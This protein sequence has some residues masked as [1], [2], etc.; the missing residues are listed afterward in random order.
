[1]QRFATDI[2]YEGTTEGVSISQ[3]SEMLL[4][5]DWPL[6]VRHES[7][8]KGRTTG[9]HQHLDFYALYVI[10]SGKGVHVID[11]I[12]SA[13]RTGDIY[14]LCPGAIH[15]Y[16][17]YQNLEI[18]AF[19]FSVELFDEG[20]RAIL[21]GMQGFWPLMHSPDTTRFHLSR[22]NW[23]QLEREIESLRAEWCDDSPAA[24]RLL[25][26]GFFRFLVMLARWRKPEDTSFSREH[27]ARV[28]AAPNV[29]AA[30]AEVLSAIESDLSKD[31]TIK[32]LAARCFLSPR[33][34]SELFRQQT[35]D[36]PAHYLARLRLEKSKFLVETSS[37]SLSQIAR[38]CGFADGAH[39]SRTFSQAFG[40]APSQWRKREK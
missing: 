39:L 31:W 24:S 20:Q 37:L 33:R 13:V 2:Q 14:L 8:S 10:R 32:N 19:Y 29:S 7:Y 3:F 38:E 34:F 35:G 40:V 9:L 12:P 5:A 11:D 26:D 30:I 18:D 23:Q 22:E 15:A 36:S 1:M 16:R 27:A 28:E 4:H 25:R 6:L 21:T 17:E